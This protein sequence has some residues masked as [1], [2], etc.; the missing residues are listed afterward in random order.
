MT[1][2]HT[3]RAGACAQHPLLVNFPAAAVA[4][5]FP[6]SVSR[7]GS[8]AVSKTASP[9]SIPGAGA[10]PHSAQRLT[11][12]PVPAAISRNTVSGAAPRVAIINLGDETARLTLRHSQTLAVT[13]DLFRAK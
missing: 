11:I 3:E 5:L 12:P 4:G 6:Q 8:A 13:L 1:H 2:A 9:G 7:S 10:K